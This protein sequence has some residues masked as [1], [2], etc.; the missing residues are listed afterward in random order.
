MRRWRELFLDLPAERLVAEA[1]LHVADGPYVYALIGD[2]GL[3]NLPILFHERDGCD[4]GRK[5]EK[6]RAIYR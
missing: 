2:D 3:G 1:V 5:P 6:A 4:A